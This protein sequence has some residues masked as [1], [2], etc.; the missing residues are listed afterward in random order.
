MSLTITKKF[1]WSIEW[2]SNLGFF[3]IELNHFDIFRNIK[4]NK[5]LVDSD[6]NCLWMCF[7]DC[8]ANQTTPRKRYLWINVWSLCSLF[9]KK[10]KMYPPR[11]S[12]LCYKN[13]EIFTIDKEKIGWIWVIGF[14]VLS[15]G[16]GLFPDWIK[17]GIENNAHV[18]FEL[19]M[20]WPEIFNGEICVNCRLSY[21]NYMS[22][23]NC[24]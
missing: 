16:L 18:K 1:E 12:L 11:K 24:V 8:L 5:L 14:P 21:S 15:K 13:L 7:I 22:V 6:V 4:K 17:P 9:F 20:A 10:W 2:T 3:M 23:T 19:G